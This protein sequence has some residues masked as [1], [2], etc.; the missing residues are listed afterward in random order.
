MGRPGPID[1]H[2]SVG[3][4]PPAYK[5]AK[6][7]NLLFSGSKAIQC[8]RGWC[9][10][11][12]DICYVKRWKS[13]ID[14]WVKTPSLLRLHHFG[15]SFSGLFVVRES[16]CQLSLG[17]AHLGSLQVVQE[18]IELGRNRCTRLQ[19]WEPGMGLASFNH[20]FRHILFLSIT[21]FLFTFLGGIPYGTY[22]QSKLTSRK[23]QKSR[24]TNQLRPGKYRIF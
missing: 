15:S 20:T 23:V 4:Y 3:T 9:F 14:G 2:D 22:G 18:F 16:C 1:S 7:P 17:W 13:K 6:T 10:L 12:L 8:R 11:F 21:R 5:N 19:S 24:R